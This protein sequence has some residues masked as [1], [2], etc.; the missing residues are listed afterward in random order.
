MASRTNITSISLYRLTSSTE[1]LAKGSRGSGCLLSPSVVNDVMTFFLI[2]NNLLT[3][4]GDSGFNGGTIEIEIWSK[5]KDVRERTNARTGRRT[6]Q[7]T[8]G[9]RE[10][11]KNAV[12]RAT[13]VYKYRTH[14]LLFGFPH[15]A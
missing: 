3:G 14:G 8:T 15:A 5:R 1:T 9:V 11:M 7:Q 4:S 10:Q 12:L 2:S 6:S 13:A